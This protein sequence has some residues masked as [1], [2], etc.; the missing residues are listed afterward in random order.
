MVSR[1]ETQ[2]GSR[3]MEPGQMDECFQPRRAA[4]QRL[5]PTDARTMKGTR[6][7]R[8]ARNRLCQTTPCLLP[9]LLPADSLSR[10]D[11]EV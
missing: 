4:C 3:P 8:P 2:L 11:V 9:S 1:A 10:C 7:T 6:R 5:Y